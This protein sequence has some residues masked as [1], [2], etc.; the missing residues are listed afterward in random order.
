[1][2]EFVLHRVLCLLIVVKTSIMLC[3]R[4]GNDI[5]W[6]REE[7][8]CLAKASLPLQRIRTSSSAFAGEWI[9]IQLKLMKSGDVRRED[10]GAGPLHKLLWE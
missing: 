8:W 4:T 10:D 2:K 6:E 7:N 5:F 1:M 9:L 3:S